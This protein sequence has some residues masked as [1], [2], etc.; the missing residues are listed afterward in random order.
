MDLRVTCF[1][2]KQK[3]NFALNFLRE[4]LPFLFKILLG[5]TVVSLW[6]V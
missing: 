2:L 1:F 4:E 5:D 6:V 3:E